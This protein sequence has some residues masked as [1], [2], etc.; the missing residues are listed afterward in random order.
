MGESGE[1]CGC[2]GEL[3]NAE[4]R[5]AANNGEGHGGSASLVAGQ[6]AVRAHGWVPSAWFA[7]VGRQDSSEDG[8]RGRVR[9]HGP[10]PALI[11]LAVVSAR[12]GKR[13]QPWATE[14]L[15]RIASTTRPNACACEPQTDLTTWDSRT[16]QPACMSQCLLRNG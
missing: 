11:C 15:C 6:L 16:F 3:E 2:D 7:D 12:D 9:L 10:L 8:G 4:V 14:S 5:S 13:P 1:R